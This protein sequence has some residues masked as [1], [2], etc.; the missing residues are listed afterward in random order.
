M[1]MRWILAPMALAAAA[2]MAQ[3]DG[4]APLA[5]R[6]SES[7]TVSPSGS[8]AV[9]GEAV[10]V[11]VGGR[12]YALDRSTGNQ[13]WRYPAGEPLTGSFRT[14]VTM[15]AGKVVAATDQRIVYAIDAKSGQLSWQYAAPSSIVGSPVATPN[16]VVFPMANNALGG[17]SLSDGAPL[18]GGKE[19]KAKDRIFPNLAVWQGSVIYLTT[20]GMTMVDANSGVERWTQRFGRL[21]SATAP[22]VYGDNIYINSATFVV[23]VR[24]STGGAR[25]ERNAESN[26]LFAPAVSDQGILAVTENERLVVLDLNGRPATRGGFPI[27]AKPG[28]SPSWA[29]RYALVPS[30]G[31]TLLLLDPKT[32]DRAWGY[33]VSEISASGRAATGGMPGPGGPGGGPGG[34]PGGLGGVAGGASQAQPTGSVAAAGPAVVSGAT[35][36]VLAMDGSLLAFDRANGVDLTAPNCQMLWP[37]PGDQVSPNPPAELVFKLEDYTS[38]INPESVKVTINGKDVAFTQDAGGLVR[39]LITQTGA[40]K[41]LPIGRATVAIKAA[42]W[43]G[44]EKTT[45]FVL[46]VDP[47]IDKPLGGPPRGGAA[48]GGMGPG[49]GGPPGGRGDL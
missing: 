23:S 37:T 15:S 34:A 1:S 14:G 39:V 20:G 18:W 11:A 3:F 31:G 41:S 35:L 30:A 4:P 27:K 29:G 28:K 38:G 7:T 36:L 26:L 33:T 9:D 25:W 5:W 13:L 43:L 47:A 42:D 22:V 8:P 24:A 48:G 10:Y 6:W 12:I 46:L 32:G 2:A 21:S 19:V 17:V 49:G 40:N 44:N 16:E 45:S